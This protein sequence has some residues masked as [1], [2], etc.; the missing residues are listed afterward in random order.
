MHAT[1][2]LSFSFPL[3]LSGSSWLHIFARIKG[4]RDGE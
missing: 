1:A 3:Q 4:V 2:A